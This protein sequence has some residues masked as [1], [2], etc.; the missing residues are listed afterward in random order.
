M[1][2]PK[3]YRRCIVKEYF[4]TVEAIVESI[5]KSSLVSCGRVEICSYDDTDVKKITASLLL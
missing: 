1:G 5:W 2:R 3:G 4:P